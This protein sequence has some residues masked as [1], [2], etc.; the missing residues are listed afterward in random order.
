MSNHET[1]FMRIVN[2]SGF[3]TVVKMPANCQASHAY[4]RDDPDKLL[5]LKFMKERTCWNFKASKYEG[6]FVCWMDSVGKA[7]VIHSSEITVRGTTTAGILAPRMGRTHNLYVCDKEDVGGSIDDAFIR[8]ETFCQEEIVKAMK[9]TIAT[10]QQ[11]IDLKRTELE[12]DSH[13]EIMSLLG[14]SYYKRT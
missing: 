8:Y 3:G 1:E 6:V 10:R 13:R 9:V 4:Y 7:C 5:A 2:E 12:A 14:Q 11:Y